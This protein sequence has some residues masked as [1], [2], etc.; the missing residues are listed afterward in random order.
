MT[1]ETK[2]EPEDKA[3]PVGD[4]SQDNALAGEVLAA[5]ATQPAPTGPWIWDAQTA[6]AA[7]AETQIGATAGEPPPIAVPEGGGFEHRENPQVTPEPVAA[8]DRATSDAWEPPRVTPIPAG[9]IAW[10][11]TKT[12]VGPT[13]APN[14][15]L[16]D[17]GT[18]DGALTPVAD[19]AATPVVDAGTLSDSG[20]GTVPAGNTEVPVS[21]TDDTPESRS[22][23]EGERERGSELRYGSRPSDREPTSSPNW[24][25]AFVCGWAGLR[26]GY[27]VYDVMLRTD[28]TQASRFMALGGYTALSVGFCAF[29]LEAL[30]WRVLRRRDRGRKNV[31][32]LLALITIAGAVCLFLFKD[33]DPVRGRI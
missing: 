17:G 6:P 31:L 8:A 20:D 1:T 9:E 12:A 28:L 23:P 11:A 27:Q 19:E 21:G 15:F 25:L 5:T 18:L 10:P 14:W 30:F 24:M 16:R 33:P 29:A 4:V 13:E 3:A 32:L 22:R 26:A 7:R 2:T